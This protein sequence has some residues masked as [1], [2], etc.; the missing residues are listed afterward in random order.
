MSKVQ[1][2][3][4]FSAHLKIFGPKAKKALS[5]QTPNPATAMIIALAK[6]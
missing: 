5:V 4:K 6:M 3:L 2:F 1:I